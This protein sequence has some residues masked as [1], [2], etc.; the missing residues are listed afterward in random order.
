M[1]RELTKIETAYYTSRKN[2]AQNFI[3]RRTAKYEAEVAM[4][5]RDIAECDAKL[6]ESLAGILPE[7]KGLEAI[8]E[9]SMK[10]EV[11]RMKKTLL[12]VEEEKRK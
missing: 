6:G 11:D 4:W 12:A 5:K 1:P 7:R 3:N 2:R 9:V 8:D 10:R